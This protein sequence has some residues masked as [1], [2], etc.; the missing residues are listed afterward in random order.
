M[1]SEISTLCADGI[2]SCDWLLE[3]APE[4]AIL[5]TVALSKLET[6]KTPALALESN[7]TLSTLIFLPVIVVVPTLNGVAILEI[8]ISF[9]PPEILPVNVLLTIIS[10]GVSIPPTLLTNWSTIS[11]KRLYSV[12]GT[13]STAS[14]VDPLRIVK[15]LFLPITFK[16]PVF[17]VYH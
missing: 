6:D 12:T 7:S 13:Y 16:A 17:S 4:A 9:S 10:E 15:F 3:Y 8:T 14:P 5:L 2:T 1:L 11:F